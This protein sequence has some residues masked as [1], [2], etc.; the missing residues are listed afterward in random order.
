[1]YVD[2]LQNIRGKS[3]ACA[4]SARGSDF[5]GVST[6]LAWDELDAGVD[7]RDFTIV[8]AP[9]RFEQVG[10]RWAAALGGRPADLSA[11]FRYAEGGK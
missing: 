5:A 7:P 9:A 1:V 11:V 8:N 6:P 4:Y 3:L 2:Y 10:D